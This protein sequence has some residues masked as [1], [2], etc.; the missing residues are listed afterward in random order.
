MSETQPVPVVP[1]VAQAHTPM[2]VMEGFF[3]AIKHGAALVYNE[4]LT[5]ES[6]I[7]KWE[8]DNPLL[9]PFIDKAV[10]F[11]EAVLTAHGIPVPAIAI[12]GQATL[13]ALKAIAAADA[14]V[15]SGH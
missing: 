1:F 5:V 4:V 7:H 13:S 2:S 8:A 12:A 3:T 10:L 11:A 15:Q 14:T 9:Q 6:R